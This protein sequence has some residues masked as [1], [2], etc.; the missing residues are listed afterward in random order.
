MRERRPSLIWCD[1]SIAPCLGEYMHART[2][3]RRSNRW[4]SWHSTTPSLVHAVT[5]REIGNRV[6]LRRRPD[7]M[8]LLPPLACLQSYLIHELE[9]GHIIVLPPAA[10]LRCVHA[11]WTCMDASCRVLRPDT[12]KP[13]GKNTSGAVKANQQRHRSLYIC[14]VLCWPAVIVLIY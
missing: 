11:C 10:D 2:R 1:C 4:L 3:M 5:C 13:S 6:W 12:T 14:S 8:L 9:G 7:A